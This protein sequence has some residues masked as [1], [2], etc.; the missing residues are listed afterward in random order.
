MDRALC[1]FGRTLSGSVKVGLW[2]IVFAVVVASATITV[3]AQTTQ[4][5]RQTDGWTIFRV[6]ADDTGIYVVGNQSSSGGQASATV[7]KFDAQGSQLWVRNLGPG[8]AEAVTV[9]N[10]FLYVAGTL[11]PS[12]T[13]V[14][15]RKAFLA[16][17]DAEG[18]QIWIRSFGSDDGSTGFLV[19][20]NETALYVGGYTYGPLR[21]LNGD[22]VDRGFVRKY[23]LDGNEGWTRQFG[24]AEFERSTLLG[25]T[26]DPTGLYLAGLFSAYSNDLRSQILLQKLDLNGNEIWTRLDD[27]FRQ[28]SLANIALAD[29]AIY[30]GG[31]RAAVVGGEGIGNTFLNR[32]DETGNKIWSRQES[33]ANGETWLETRD[34][35]ADQTGVYAA[36][37]HFWLTADRPYGATTTIKKYD[38]SGSVLW[39]QEFEQ[40]PESSL[41]DAVSVYGDALIVGVNALITPQRIQT[42]VLMKLA[43]GAP[44]VY[45]GPP[46]QIATAGIRNSASLSVDPSI[47]QG[48]VFTVFGDN[49]GPD[50]P[51]QANGFPLPTSGGL[52]GT[53]VRVAVNG[54]SLDAPILYTSAKQVSA[55]LPSATPLGS[56]TLTVTYEGLEASPAPIT[57]VGRSFAIYTVSQN[58]QGPGVVQNVYSPTDI[59]T[60][61]LFETARAGQAA[62]LWGT[63]LGAVSGNEA[64][65]VLP[66]DQ[67]AL[68]MHLWVGGRDATV[69][70]RGRSGCCAGVDQINFIVPDGVEGCYVPITVQV[71][72]S[73]SPYSSMSIRSDGGTCS[74]PFGLTSADL[75]AA[76]ARGG[77]RL[78]NI[79]LN[80]YT[81]LFRNSGD[82]E[83]GAV[84]TADFYNFPVTEFGNVDE[85]TS[86]SQLGIE[87]SLGDL[88]GIARHVA[89][90]TCTVSTHLMPE[91][92]SGT[93]LDA[94]SISV[95]GTSLG[96]RPGH[97]YFG[98]YPLFPGMVSGTGGAT[99]PA[100]GAFQVAASPLRALSANIPASLD[101]AAGTLV[102]WF[103]GDPDGFIYI[104]GWVEPS[105]PRTGTVFTCLERASKGSFLVPPSVTLAF[106]EV[107]APSTDSFPEPYIEVVGISPPV[108]FDA[109]GL[110]A[111]F[112]TTETAVVWHTDF[113]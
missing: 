88:W 77:I 6:A 35:T 89:P 58:G 20:V 34:I 41:A 45:D 47:A 52:A 92:N 48:S 98:G 72:D 110:D 14:T 69:F 79:R 107:K 90:G 33:A 81:L 63:G 27:D 53:S 15:G 32:Y 57:V 70:Y 93:P 65:G 100:V 18:S 13:T 46:P 29:S 82:S 56:G 109:A 2:L 40:S 5:E 104:I 106:P 39:T 36:G 38:L 113:N 31:T 51:V 17:F 73:I 61:T 54:T 50:S 24:T 95:D 103:G 75:D 68:D 67:S 59:R 94:G 43:S 21:N 3:R 84:G 66:G 9:K 26:I 97:Y 55:I 11:V 28:I 49:L 102:K 7:A 19:A 71:G 76:R 1:G 78:G 30:V 16:K 37:A 91:P 111:G 99:A 64:A 62:V 85:F 101:R 12:S 105:P 112:V 23:D 22:T 10:H 80:N 42:G 44:P 60:N 83:I 108:R 8:S 96:S 86:S 25:L 74:L 87:G 4:W